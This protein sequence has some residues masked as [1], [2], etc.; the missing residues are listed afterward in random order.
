M[1]QA[2]LRSAALYG[3]VSPWVVSIYVA[4]AY[5]VNIVNSIVDCKLRGRDL[6]TVQSRDAVSLLWPLRLKIYP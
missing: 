2:S 1:L 4:L 6:I 5:G 3:S